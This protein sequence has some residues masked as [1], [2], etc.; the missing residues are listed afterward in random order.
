MGSTGGKDILWKP[1]AAGE[2]WWV[3]DGPQERPGHG[4]P[5]VLGHR[6][7]ILHPPGLNCFR[8]W[9]GT[10]CVYPLLFEAAC[11][12]QLYSTFLTAL[13]KAVIV[14]HLFFCM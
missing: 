8:G 7:P 12:G 6:N 13:G 14:S 4:N 3:D 10:Y 1:A 2:W 9:F 5:L 11:P